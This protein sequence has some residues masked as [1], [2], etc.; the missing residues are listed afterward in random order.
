MPEIIFNPNE[1]IL[2]KIRNVKSYDPDTDELIGYYTQ[3]E[4]PTLEFTTNSTDV[5]D[6]MQ[7]P[8]YTIYN[9][10][11]GTFS[12]TNSLFSLDL[13]ALQFGTKKQVADETNKLIVPMSETLEIGSDASVTLKYS[14]V[15]T[16]GAEIPY[17]TILKSDNTFG[18]KFKVG[19][20]AASGEENTFTIDTTAK[21]LQFPEGTTGRVI[22]DYNRES[23]QAAIV[24]KNTDGIPQVSKLIIE[25]IFHDKCNTNNVIAG[26][27]ICYRAQVD[28]SSV[29]LNLTAEGKHAVT[30]KLQ[31]PYCDADG[32]LV[33]VVVV[34]D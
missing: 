5:L 17:V 22:V 18:T 21:K 26:Y 7:T 8:I 20:T 11:T 13:A 19:A 10:Q 29:S 12:F 33:D 34:N 30:F 16:V 27:I 25:A 2:E 1:L 15:G 32:K 3:I 23:A 24:T 14:P 6:A 4:E 31:K 28:P 9:G